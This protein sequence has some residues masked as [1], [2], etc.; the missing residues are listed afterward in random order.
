MPAKKNKTEVQEEA[1]LEET[2]VAEKV[3]TP[4]KETKKAAEKSV[5]AEPVRKAINEV[6]RR[7]VANKK[8][9]G[10]Y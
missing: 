7:R 5:V 4:K 10:F 6:E 8:L 2:K 9:P 3:E 1:T